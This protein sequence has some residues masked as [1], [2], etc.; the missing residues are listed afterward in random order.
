VLLNLGEDV[1]I[2]VGEIEEE[3][4][5]D[6]EDEEEVTEVLVVEFNGEEDGKEA[7]DFFSEVEFD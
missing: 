3:R 7:I 2:Y 1:A 6:E 5:D 4:L